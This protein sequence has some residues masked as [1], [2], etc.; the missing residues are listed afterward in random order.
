MKGYG[1]LTPLLA[2]PLLFSV[3]GFAQPAPRPGLSNPVPQG[4]PLPRVLPA[5]PPAL[6]PAVAPPAA[7][8]AAPTPDLNVV[9]REVRLE[10][11]TAYAP[12]ELNPLVAGLVGSSV[13][14]ERIEEARL[15]LLRRYRDGGYP[16]TAVSAEVEQGGRLRFV[17]AEGRV[18]EVRLD[19]D[20]GPAA[21]QVLKFLDGLV[22]AGPLDQARLERQLLLAQEVPGITV[23]A[24]LRP[25]PGGEP[26]AL[27]LIAQVSR[28]P[29]SGL[30]AGDNRGYELIG[31]DQVVA[32]LSGNSFT[33]YGERTDVVLFRSTDATQTYGQAAVEAFIG[34]SGLRFRIQ[35]GYGETRPSGTLRAIG[36]EG[37]TTQF[38]GGLIYPVIRQRDQSLTVFGLLEALESEV[39]LAGPG[40]QPSR[41]SFDSLRPVRAGAEWARRDRLLG[42][43]LPGLTTAAVRLSQGLSGLGASS[44]GAEFA[45]RVGQVIDFFK[46]NGEITR[47]QALFAPWDGASVSLFGLVSGQWTRDILPSIEKFQLGGLRLNRGFYAGEVTGDRALATTIELRLDDAWT[48]PVWGQSFDIA[49]QF[50]AFYDWGQ[51]WERQPEQADRRLASAGGGVRMVVDR[52]TELQLEGVSRL[53]RSPQGALQVEPL[54]SNAVYWRVLTRF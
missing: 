16:L 30:I 26:G 40:G 47:S 15:A 4:S 43:G 5:R 3:E 11:V 34:S 31:P 23:R 42:D 37:T 18:A 49:A 38:S 7:P 17:V 45:G 19:G 25:I 36:Y 51:S 24:V 1:R 21:T 46:V 50:Y 28:Q 33:Q 12:A 2:L 10:G 53:T 27:Q 35:G 14:L 29:F 8:A 13:P 6:A 20:I 22:T 52:R 41:A 48:L 32:V 9:I 54:S 39:L 44:E